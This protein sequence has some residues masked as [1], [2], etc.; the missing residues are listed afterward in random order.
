MLESKSYSHCC[1]FDIICCLKSKKDDDSEYK[2]FLVRIFE[3]FYAPFL[4][5]KWVKPSVIVI[6]FGWLCVS[7]AVA[8][9]LEVGLDQVMYWQK[10]Q[11][12][13]KFQ[14]RES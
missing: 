13:I 6:F 10:V 7:V 3:S 11:R 14:N 2:S 4:M 5:N 12:N 9:K 8:P 1:R